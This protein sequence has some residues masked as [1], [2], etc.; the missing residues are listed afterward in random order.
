MNIKWGIDKVHINVGRHCPYSRYYV[1]GSRAR[2]LLFCPR[3]DLLTLVSKHCID[4]AGRCHQANV[5]H[6]FCT[7]VS[8]DLCG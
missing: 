8:N 2:F 3:Y 6:R 7:I 4:V 1:I 5:R